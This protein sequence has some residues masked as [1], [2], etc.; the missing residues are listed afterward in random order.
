MVFSPRLKTEIRKPVKKHGF[1]VASS[2]N[3][4]DDLTESVE[5]YDRFLQH[6]SS[7]PATGG[8]RPRPQ[9]KKKTSK[10]SHPRR[11]TK[12]QVRKHRKRRHTQR[13][14]VGG[15][16]PPSTPKS[17]L[18]Q[19]VEEL[20]QSR[21]SG[22]RPPRGNLENLLVPTAL[23]M[24]FA[25]QGLTDHEANFMLENLNYDNMSSFAAKPSSERTA[26]ISKHTDAP[27]YPGPPPPPPRG[28]PVCKKKVCSDPD[29]C[30]HK[31]GNWLGL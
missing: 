28:C 26:I 9:S 5:A 27:R 20:Q 23:K 29:F 25:D 15:T 14:V 18:Q 4:F 7:T 22:T 3:R 2:A 21:Q 30:E 12:R 1:D 11:N 13:R 31:M 24:R 8:K 19:R 16:K 17:R 6:L 10:R